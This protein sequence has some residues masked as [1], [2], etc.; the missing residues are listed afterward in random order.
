[1]STHSNSPDLGNVEAGFGE[2]GF[3]S[4]DDTLVVTTPASGTSPKQNVLDLDTVSDLLKHQGQR[5]IHTF[6]RRASGGG[7]LPSHHM[8]LNTNETRSNQP[9]GGLDF[10]YG[11]IHTENSGYLS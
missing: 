5:P 11:S 1:M 3:D 6:E 2:S 7:I 9:D 10:N 4:K 8:S